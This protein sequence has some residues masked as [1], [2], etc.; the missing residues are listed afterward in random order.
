VCDNDI[1]RLSLAAWP[2]TFEL[3]VCSVLGVYPEKWGKRKPGK[4][5]EKIEKLENPY[6]F[7]TDFWLYIFRYPRILTV[8][9]M[10]KKE[11]GL[12][13][14]DDVQICERRQAARWRAELLLVL[15]KPKFT[16]KPNTATIEF[17]VFYAT[18]DCLQLAL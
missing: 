3:H 6:H 14:Q 9:H 16:L 8:G 13:E 17:G 1:L 10:S 15:L 2:H 7:T 5:R 18:S 4:V 11:L 12:I